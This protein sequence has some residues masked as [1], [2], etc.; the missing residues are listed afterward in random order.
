M[1]ERQH[2]DDSALQSHLLQ[3]RALLHRFTALLF[4]D[5]SADQWEILRLLP[6]DRSLAAAAAWLRKEPVVRQCSFGRGELPERY[7]KP[8]E[9]L[10]HLPQTAD[11]LV[12]EHGRVFGLVAA[13]ACPPYATE[14][15]PAKFAFQRSHMLADMAGFYR[16]FGLQLSPTRRE[17]PDHVVC[18]FQFMA[19]VAELERRAWQEDSSEFLERRQICR[20]AQRRFFRD[21]VA[22][23]TPLF[24]TLVVQQDEQGFYGAAARWLAAWVRAERALLGLTVPQLTPELSM[25][26]PPDMCQGCLVPPP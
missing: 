14:Y 10:R 3:A 20:D 11:D 16:A 5:V 8:S 1:A 22:F 18:Q 6:Q 12:A 21:Y 2:S 7:L 19:Y 25:V 26:E 17:R 9:L 15:V 24:A 4:C 13:G 23:W